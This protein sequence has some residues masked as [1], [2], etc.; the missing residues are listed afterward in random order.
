L[1]V[2]IL[3]CAEGGAITGS[4]GTSE[5]GGT[6]E[7]GGQVGS[8]GTPES[9]GQVGTGGA[10]GTGG[11]V[12]TGGT[13]GTGGQ[14][15]T[16][17]APGS[18]G[19]TG[20]GG[21]MASLGGATGRAGRT[22]TTSR[23][24]GAT[25]PGGSPG[26]GGAPS[27]GGSTGAPFSHKKFFGNIDTSGSIRSDFNT[28]W[29]QF[30]PENAGKWGSVQG[31]SQSSFNWGSLDRMYK[32]CTDNNIIFKEHC[33][34][35]G[36]QQPSWADASNGEAALKNWM[37]QF[38]QRYPKVAV[39]DVVNEPLH[40]TPRYR[41]GIGG[42]GASGWDWIVNALK[43]AKEA[44]PNAVLIVNEYNTIE[45]SGENGRIISLA[46]AVKGA[47]APLMA[48]GAQAH[49]VA[50]VSSA[51][52]KNYA[53]KIIAETGLPLYITEM[54]IG[55]ADDNQ[56]AQMMR[57]FVTPLWANDKVPGFTYW[58]YIVGRTWRAN[59]GLMTDSGT[60]RPALTWL[61]SFLN[62]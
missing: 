15:G 1:A 49:D 38:C 32:Y 22:G 48:L 37:T 51:T 43:W 13:P 3:G 44:C 21:S 56:Q 23:A 16:G 34:S 9:G 60:K 39:I 36:A 59:T 45:Y 52:L 58:G 10:P 19:E 18:S 35:W 8:G 53:E 20:A 57:D 11:K 24:G 17:G 6:P 50:K 14:V 46:K 4:G 40:T 2:S 41:D 47:G 42:T 31:S 61:M 33:F 12:G 25:S 26:V 27:A 29:D 7:T 54:D 55:V 30:S 28:M 62:R 5:S